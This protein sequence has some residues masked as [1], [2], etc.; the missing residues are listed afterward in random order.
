MV[1]NLSSQLSDEVSRA[2]AEASRR[3][4]EAGDRIGGLAERFDQSSGR[5][6]AEMDTAVTR[7]AQAVDDL[8]QGMSATAATASGAFTEGAEQML[9]V[10]NRTLE[11]IRDNTAEGA[12]AMSAAA[13]DLKA[14]A[15]G[16]RGEIERAT[17]EGADA[18]RAS[19]TAAGAQAGGAIDA[20][21]KGVLDAFGRTSGEIARLAET[22]ADKTGRDLLAPLDKVA[23]RFGGLI[24]TL[25]EGTR[26]MHRLSDGIKA[27]SE[28]TESAATAFRTAAKDLVDATAP[29]RAANERLETSVR[30][31]A[32]STRQAATVV[33][34]S[35]ETTARAGADVLSAAREALGGQGRAIEAALAGVSTIID[36]MRQQSVEL[37]RV[38][39]KLVT[40]FE[41]YERHVAASVSTLFE[42]VKAMNDRL[43]PA[44]DTM[45]EIVEQAEQFAPESRR[46]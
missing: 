10:M 18:A 42:H 13:G 41:A 1:S 28:A 44:L 23:D 2:L 31:L 19:L 32:D 26:G 5:M 21:G 7:L 35:A 17:R 3:L 33:T 22:L 8:R 43:A 40:A 9:S 34:T 11:G 36:K 20:A 6:G 24:E 14:A 12:R 4:A 39:E 15:E 30:G 16:F 38:D 46:R 37:D 45:R 27:G 29:I 25:S